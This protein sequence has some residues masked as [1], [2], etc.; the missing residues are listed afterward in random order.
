MDK[1]FKLSIFDVF[2]LFDDYQF[3]N[4]ITRQFN[5]E[6]RRALR[7]GPLAEAVVVVES[8]MGTGGG[9]A[10]TAKEMGSELAGQAGRHRVSAQTAGGKQIDIDLAGKRHYD[11]P[12][13]TWIETPHVH[14][15]QI[16]VGPA[17][18]ISTSGK[19]TRP[20]TKADIRT[21][22]KILERE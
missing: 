16:N 15:S 13:G 7:V 18:Q 3:Y 1:N 6:G 20:A 4:C 11:K 22:R 14:E 8:L 10:K 19:T 12:S 17:G 2:I 9:A 5:R 21:A